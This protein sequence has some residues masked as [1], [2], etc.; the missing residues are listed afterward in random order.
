MF[1]FRETFWNIEYWNEHGLEYW[2][3]YLFVDGVQWQIF[4]PFLLG[5]CLILFYYTFIKSRRK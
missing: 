4:I 2:L 5:I 3:D 1:I